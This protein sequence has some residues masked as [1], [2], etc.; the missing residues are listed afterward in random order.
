MGIYE[1]LKS[2][3]KHF[4]VFEQHKENGGLEVCRWCIS[5]SATCFFLKKKTNKKNPETLLNFLSLYDLSSAACV[6]R[7]S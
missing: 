4:Y 7:K 6:H 3:W 2:P 5:P 1:I